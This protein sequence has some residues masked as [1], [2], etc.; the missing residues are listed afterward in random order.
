MV[1][2][3]DKVCARHEREPLGVDGVQ[4]DDRSP[5]SVGESV[6]RPRAE[7]LVTWC[8]LRAACSV[9]HM[10]GATLSDHWGPHPPAA[11][12]LSLYEDAYGPRAPPLGGQNSGLEDARIG[13]VGN[14][15]RERRR[16]CIAGYDASD[17]DT[18]RAIAGLEEG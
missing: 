17:A 15:T 9:R 10:V 3:E 1:N 11:L 7:D 16:G 13:A 6:Q 14:H 4:C 18:Q 8:H 5:G 2:I 12:G